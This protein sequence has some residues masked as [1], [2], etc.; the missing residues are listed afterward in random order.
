MRSDAWTVS[1]GGA[2]L[3]VS[4]VGPPEAP[5]W[6]LAHGA[7]SSARFV[8]AA[9]AGP[10]LATGRRLI[11]YDLR[12]HGASSPARAPEDHHLDVHAGDLAAVVARVPGVEVVGGI[13]LGAHVAVRAVAD[14][15]A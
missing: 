15:L 1:V 12:G 6:V 10:V 13:S 11:A 8:R 4:E 2:Q 5:A 3:A 7:G 9:F 14:G